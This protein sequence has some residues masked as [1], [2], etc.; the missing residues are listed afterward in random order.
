MPA[1]G[2]IVAIAPPP[3]LRQRRTFMFQTAMFLDLMDLFCRKCHAESASKGF[4]TGSDNDNIPTKIALLHSE[5]SEML[6]A[7]RAGN[8]PCDKSIPD[9]NGSVDFLAVIQDG[10]LRRLTSMEEEAADVLIRLG[11]LCGKLR[12][13]LGRVTLEKMRYNA[14]R[15][16]M[17][18]GKRI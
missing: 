3:V 7:F 17:H 15:E 16:H 5:L 12:I 13:D 14:Q 18:G 9:G 1:A 10:E 8:P 4:W 11:D 2:A 6:E